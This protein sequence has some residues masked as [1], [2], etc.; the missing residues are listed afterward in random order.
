MT[1]T[2]YSTPII[3]EQNPFYCPSV[4]AASFLQSL[5]Q[6]VSLESHSRHT[7]G[8]SQGQDEFSTPSFAKLLDQSISEEDL[9][10]LMYRRPTLP[11]SPLDEDSSLDSIYPVSHRLGYRQP[12]SDVDRERREPSV[13]SESFSDL[14]GPMIHERS[15]LAVNDGSFELSAKAD[16]IQYFPKMI[17]FTPSDPTRRNYGAIAVDSDRDVHV[18]NLSGKIRVLEG[19][20]FQTFVQV[21]M[22]R[23]RVSYRPGYERFR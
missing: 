2:K 23:H 8:Y 21:L 17:G 1:L 15:F 4:P 19:T 13:A 10:D 20:L 7:L 22:C 5:R 3:D 6:K 18:Q 9:L 11:G 14:Q 16:R 12:G